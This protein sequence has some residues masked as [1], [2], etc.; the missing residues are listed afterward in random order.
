VKDTVWDL[1]SVGNIRKLEERLQMAN[2]ARSKTVTSGGEKFLDW[3]TH[4]TVYSLGEESVAI[5]TYERTICGHPVCEY[6]GGCVVIRVGD[7]NYRKVLLNL[8]V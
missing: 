7:E 8:P 2:F 6:F 5:Y 4:K 1:E 3:L